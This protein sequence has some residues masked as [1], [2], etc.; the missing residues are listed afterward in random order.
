MTQPALATAADYAD[1]LLTA[2]RFKSVLFFVVL[3]ALLVQITL[4]FLARY[5]VLPV[6]TAASAAADATT[7]TTQPAS[8]NGPLLLQYLTIAGTFL[9]FGATIVLSLVLL[10]IAAIML[11]GRLIGVG[12]ITSAFLWCIVL[13]VMLFPW[14][15]VYSNAALRPDGTTAI[16]DFRIPGVL[17]TWAEISHP[18][19]GAKFS[20]DAG[21][22]AYLRW[23]RF[24]GFPVVAVLVLL[25]VQLTSGRALR[26]ALGDDVT[27]DAGGGGVSHSH[28]MKD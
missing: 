2:R 1:A 18:T 28:T 20:G 24:V 21:H 6:T 4:F 5:D 11:V 8:L 23:A 17:Y 19:L 12:R 7:S 14:Q 16:N 26:Q 27:V 13:L 3:V 15:A 10:L 25:T 9:G 22:V